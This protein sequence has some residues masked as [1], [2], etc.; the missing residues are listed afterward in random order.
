[1]YDNGDIL[2]FALSAWRQ[3]SWV[4]FKRCFDEIQRKSAASGHYDET[5]NATGHRWRALRDLS[6]LGHIDLHFIQGGVRVCVAPPTLAALPGFG[7]PRAVLCGGRSPRLIRELETTA[8][9]AGLELAIDSQS[10]AS[11]Y[12]PARV[13]V[14]A[15]DPARIHSLANDAGISYLGVPPARLLARVSISLAEYRQ[16][17]AWSNEPELNWHR[18][19]F[20]TGRLH[21]RPAGETSPHRRLSRYRDPTTFVWHYRL[22]QGNGSAEVALDWGR[23]AILSSTSWRVLQYFPEQS[24]AVVPYGTPLPTLLARAFGLCSGYCPTESNA[25]QTKPLGRCQEFH[26]VPPSV[27]NSVTSKLEQATS[28]GR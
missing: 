13:E 16:H 28:R 15:V 14:R 12:V 3:T 20:D 10:T 19:D 1:M 22:W 7:S 18:E 4:Q 27:F 23:Y 9:A 21:F 26:G 24:K 5:G 2:L 17:L 25:A 6:A 8:A 11:P